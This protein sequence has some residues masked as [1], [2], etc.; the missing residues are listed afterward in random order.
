[1]PLGNLP[2]LCAFPHPSAE[3][4]IIVNVGVL[5]IPVYLP[6]ISMVHLMIQMCS[7]LEQER[8]LEKEASGMRT[9]TKLRTFLKKKKKVEIT[10]K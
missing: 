8:H 2:P 3:L 7:P 6:Y 10:L 5:E 1:M 9:L 4:G